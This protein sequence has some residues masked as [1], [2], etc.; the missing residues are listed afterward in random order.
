MR[1]NLISAGRDEMGRL[2]AFY[3]QNSGK[4]AG[5]AEN[6]PFNPSNHKQTRFNKPFF[7]LL[8]CPIT[9]RICSGYV[10][11]FS[12]FLASTARYSAKTLVSLLA[13][14]SFTGSAYAE[15]VPSEANY[16]K[17]VNAIYKAEG[18]AKTRHP[19]GILT[20]YKHTTPRQACFNTVRN[21]YKRWERAGRPGDYISF[22]GARYAPVGAKNDPTGLNRNWVR[23]V[24]SLMGEI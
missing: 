9:Y 7:K 12:S 15:F 16:T 4:S 1:V 5:F 23:N 14:L 6:F 22:L 13:L 3:D 10:Y 20:K 18:G 24:K 17:L 21:T 19:Y 11:F 8:E 2:K